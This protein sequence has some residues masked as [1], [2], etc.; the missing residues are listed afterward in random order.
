M[1]AQ[2]TSP[3]SCT[4]PMK[5]SKKKFVQEGDLIELISLKKKN[6]QLDSANNTYLHHAVS[7]KKSTIE[8][9]EQLSKSSSSLYQQNTDGDT[10]F[11][12]AI[13]KGYYNFVDTMIKKAQIDNNL[14]E[15]LLTENQLGDTPLSI[16][17]RLKYNT[18]YKKLAKFTPGYSLTQLKT[19]KDSRMAR[20]SKI[21]R[22]ALVNAFMETFCPTSSPS[23]II[24]SF[25][26]VGLVSASFA[27]NI[28]LG[29][30]A[31][32]S[33]AIITYFNYKKNKAKA[34]YDKKIVDHE[35]ALSIMTNIQWREYLSRLNQKL[36]QGQ[37]LSQDEKNELANIQSTL[38][39]IKTTN[40]P[41]GAIKSAADFAT[42]ED[43]RTIAVST[44]ATILCALS[45]VLSIGTL[46][47]S[48]YAAGAGITM[49]AALVAAGP[50]GLGI[51][52]CIGI[53]LAAVITAWHVKTRRSELDE[54]GKG[55]YN[56]FIIQNQC[57]TKKA[58]LANDNTLSHIDSL[59]EGKPFIETKKSPTEQK[60]NKKDAIEEK[61]HK[62]WIKQHEHDHAIGEICQKDVDLLL[63]MKR[64]NN[65]K[66][67][68]H[69]DLA[70]PRQTIGHTHH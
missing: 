70:S 4:N 12:L 30:V 32:A 67:L 15:L 19:I 26:L 24:E 8:V 50:I 48:I 25:A 28:G 18:I 16:A 54:L 62:P 40:P 69:L 58:T 1:N 68:V 64:N 20:G 23:G 49:G 6:N 41:K 66:R 14:N 61:S 47:L 37:I 7:D 63:K 46:G 36:H 10:P 17:A 44:A 21:K 13:K 29:I 43:K 9:I 2:S 22:H 11:H 55:R 38:A 3:G 42:N 5:K 27:F 52:L 45:G 34:S 35:Y 56:A 60:P 57:A 65:L 31:L 39:T 53:A 33:F 59:L 51:A